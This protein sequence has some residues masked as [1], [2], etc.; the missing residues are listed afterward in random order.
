MT[1]NRLHAV[2]QVMTGI[3][4]VHAEFKQVGIVTKR[5][6]ASS[7]AILGRTCEA[8]GERGERQFPILLLDKAAGPSHRWYATGT[9]YGVVQVLLAN[10]LV[11]I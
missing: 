6:G 2:T 7:G 1:K 8:A 11:S 4:C 3:A 5:Q 10:L 9:S